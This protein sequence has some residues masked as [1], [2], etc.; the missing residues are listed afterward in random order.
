MRTV[1]ARTFGSILWL[2]HGFVLIF[3]ANSSIVS[4]LKKY[5]G[6][7]EFSVMRMRS[8]FTAS[9]SKIAHCGPADQS[10]ACEPSLIWSAAA[11]KLTGLYFVRPMFFQSPWT[12][13]F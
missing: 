1:S 13:G 12:Y 7:T 3:S 5:C 2:I 4:A 11:M 9:E 6:S 10:G 8:R